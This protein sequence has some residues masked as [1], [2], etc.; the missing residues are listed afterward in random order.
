MTA[1]GCLKNS[2][3]LDATPCVLDDEHET[4]CPISGASNVVHREAPIA[5]RQW[6]LPHVVAGELRHPFRRHE[7]REGLTGVHVPGGR[8]RFNTC[9]EVDVRPGVVSRG[10]VTN[11]QA[12]LRKALRPTRRSA[13]ATNRSSRAN[14]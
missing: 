14:W 7:S 10:L 8:D 5:F 9:R 4:P 1:A 12:A 6:R 3:W 2:G 11:S 13:P